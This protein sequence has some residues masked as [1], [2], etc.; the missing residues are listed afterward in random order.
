MLPSIILSSEKQSAWRQRRLKELS[1]FCSNQSYRNIIK[2][3][4]WE[5]FLASIEKISIAP[6]GQRK[7]R[8]LLHHTETQNLL[9][10]FRHNTGV[11]TS[12]R[13]SVTG[14]SGIPPPFWQIHPNSKRWSQSPTVTTN[15]KT[16]RRD[17]YVTSNLQNLTGAHRQD[18]NNLKISSWSDH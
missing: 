4:G 10:I 17:N 3:F 18:M 15:P 12:S 14:W 16:M 6:I 7:A 9:T 8:T 11:E 2:G 1:Y 5:Q 13:F